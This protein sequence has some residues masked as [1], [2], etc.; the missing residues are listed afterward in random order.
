MG[1]P[2]KSAGRELGGGVSLVGVGSGRAVEYSGIQLAAA[3]PNSA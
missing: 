3:H 1:V 2:L